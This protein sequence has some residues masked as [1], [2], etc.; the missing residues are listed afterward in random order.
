MNLLTTEGRVEL[1]RYTT[2]H[3]GWA[4]QREKLYK[5]RTRGSLCVVG[6]CR[7]THGEL[8]GQLGSVSVPWSPRFIMIGNSLASR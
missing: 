7:D 8:W 1:V 3:L 6:S 4:R 5:R 2:L